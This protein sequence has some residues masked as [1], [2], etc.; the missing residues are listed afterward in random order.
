MISKNRIK[1]IN[2][3]KQKK[4]RQEIG[5]FIV[6]G[7]K[8]A[9]EILKSNFCIQTIVATTE[10][11]AENFNILPD[12]EI[13][14]TNE[15]G[16]KKVSGLTTAQKVLLLVEIPKNH[17]S[18]SD[19]EKLI[20][21]LDNINDPGNLGTIIRIADWF[22]VGKVVCSLCSV[23]VFNP[24][25]VQ[26]TMGAIARVGVIYADLTKYIGNAKKN[27]LPVYGTFL[28]GKN[29]YN[30]RL[31]RNGIIVMGSEARGISP[32]IEKLIDQKIHIPS[33]PSAQPTSES[34]NIS[35]ATAI[36]CAEFRR[37]CI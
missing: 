14:E 1:Q 17:S 18:E 4:N 37:R 6:E 36:V 23:D 8:L 25:A 30:E 9:D 7:K 27:N 12:C 28:K 21:A 13:V 5:L 19:S 35:T 15:A 11:L 22:G 33:F 34:L 29:I 24:K 2:A 3:L 26:A 31:T 32:E 10:W 20:L 16:L